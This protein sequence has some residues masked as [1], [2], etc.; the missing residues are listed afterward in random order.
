MN[1]EKNIL[2]A[3]IKEITNRKIV[4]ATIFVILG[5]IFYAIAVTWI[6]RLGN[7]F[8]G[9]ATGASQI[10]VR[11]A[12]QLFNIDLPLGL[13]IF[14]VNVPLFLIG[15]RHVSKR[16]AILTLVS[17][18]VQSL[19]VS[20]LEKIQEA[21]FN[22]FMEFADNRLLLALLGGGLA[23]LGASFCLKHGGSS[24]GIDI[25]SNMMLVKNKSSFGKYVFIVDFIILFLSIFNFSNGTVTYEFGNA[26]FTLIR[27]I[28]YLLTVETVYTSYR[29]IKIQIITT[30]ADE[31]TKLLLEK[32]KHGITVYDAIGAYTKQ[33]KNVLEIYAS[34]Y[35]LNDYIA[36]AQYVD[37][38]AFIT[39]C[40]VRT[41]KGNYLKKTIV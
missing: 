30:K 27:L 34:H 8:A 17:I 24:G 20:I 41:I 15:F 25:I 16:F 37:P 9:G 33:Q 6:F 36:I 18:L 32:I 40:S 29:P 12:S 21:G 10:F 4:K 3:D 28:A 1:T 38:Q 7:F 5:S 35:E 39:I 23:G 31:M 14:I 11:F 26:V 19:S 2:T 22:P 13:I